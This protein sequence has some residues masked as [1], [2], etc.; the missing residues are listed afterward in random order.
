MVTFS[1]RWGL[2]QRLQNPLKRLHVILELHQ[3]FL[4]HSIIRQE[5]SPTLLV[6]VLPLR[7]CEILNV[8]SM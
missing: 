6:V 3:N 1:P 4:I 5:V 7:P 8:W 2:P